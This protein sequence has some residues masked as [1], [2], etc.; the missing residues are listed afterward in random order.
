M[1]V[2]RVVTSTT[3][4]TKSVIII[5]LV[6]VNTVNVNLV[7]SVVVVVVVI[8]II[9]VVVINVVC[10]TKKCYYCDHCYGFKCYY[11]DLVK[12]IANVVLDYSSKR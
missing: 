2:D 12:I 8:V 10:R 6:I 11:R 5:I 3:M 7:I 1:G 9:I 4:A